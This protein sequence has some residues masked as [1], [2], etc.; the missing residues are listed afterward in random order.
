MLDMEM[1]DEEKLAQLLQQ[2]LKLRRFESGE[3]PIET[4]AL[5][6]IEDNFAVD[7]NCLPIGFAHGQLLLAMMDP[8]DDDVQEYVSRMSGYPVQPL[9]A[10]R[11][12]LERAHDDAMKSVERE[13]AQRETVAVPAHFKL[14]M[15]AIMFFG[16]PEGVGKTF[17]MW[18]L[19]HVVSKHHRVLLVEIGL[20]DSGEEGDA[21]NE[22]AVSPY[23]LHNV[24]SDLIYVPDPCMLP[25][26]LQELA[27][28]SERQ[29]KSGFELVFAELGE[30]AVGVRECQI[31]EW[32]ELLVLV[33]EAKHAAESGELLREMLQDLDGQKPV[34]VGVIFNRAKSV[35]QGEAGFAALEAATRYLRAKKAFRLWFGGIIPFAPKAVAKSE[36]M[37][38]VVVDAFPREPVARHIRTIAKRLIQD[39]TDQGA[40]L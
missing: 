17:L 4:D 3:T 40:L 26:A 23:H 15:P 39:L 12:D 19:A 24:D 33:T 35:E 13:A 32:A 1:V 9:V 10:T 6:V 31:A 30:G 29:N 20:P 5:L 2:R 27:E 37:G 34:S 18:N 16:H 25:D 14:A 22:K 7:H 11:T 38:K 36:Q 28:E 8:L 21:L